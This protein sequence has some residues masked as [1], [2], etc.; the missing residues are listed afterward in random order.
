MVFDSPDPAELA[1]WWAAALPWDVAGSGEYHAE[2]RPPDD[3]DILCLGFELVDDPKV[4][5]NRVHLDLPPAS[6]VDQ[7]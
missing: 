1:G 3:A 5:K 7:L 2:V 6:T 4:V